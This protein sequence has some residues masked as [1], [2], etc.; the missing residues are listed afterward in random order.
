LNS[1]YLV[2]FFFYFSGTVRG[3]RDMSIGDSATG[4]TIGIWLSGFRSSWWGN[5]A[6]ILARVTLEGNSHGGHGWVRVSILARKVL[7]ESL[8]HSRHLGRRSPQ[9]FCSFFCVHLVLSECSMFCF[10]RVCSESESV[11]IFEDWNSQDVD[12]FITWI[13]LLTDLALFS[14][15]SLSISKNFSE[16]WGVRLFERGSVCALVPRLHFGS[17]SASV[18]HKIVKWWRG[19]AEPKTIN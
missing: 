17:G 8:R 3:A 1:I 11:L 9:N 4:R 6:E 7:T 14:Y 16:N 5:E 19:Y 2:I 18:S 15:F 12:H 10:I 13:L